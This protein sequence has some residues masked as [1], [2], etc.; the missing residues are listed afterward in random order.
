MEFGISE[1]VELRGSAVC[2]AALFFCFV[3]GEILV[4]GHRNPDTDSICSAIGYAE[5]KRL[6][7]SKRVIA[8]RCGD[9][10]DRINFVLRRFGAAPPRFVADVSPK[11]RDVMQHQVS[12]IS[13]GATASE[14]LAMMEA[15]NLRVLPIVDEDRFCHGLISVFKMGKFLMAAGNR[16]F[17]SRRVVASIRALARTLGAKLRFGVYADREEDLILMVGAMSRDSF[18]TRLPNYPPEKLIVVVGDRR[19]IQELAV[20]HR[21]RAIIVTGDLAV[22]EDVAAR[23]RRNEVSLLVS[24][25]DSATTV[26]LC[27]SAIGVEH[28]KHEHFLSFREDEAVAAIRDVAVSSQFQAFPVLDAL[29]RVVGV[30]S[31]TDLL[32]RVDRK[33]ILVDHN[34]LSQAVK[35][36]DQVEIIEIIDHHRIGAFTSRQPMLFV[37]RPVGS[38]STIVADLFFTYQLP[39]SKQIAGLLMAGLV[40]DTLNLTSPTTTELDASVLSR[41][42]VVTSIDP[43]VF[44]EQLFSSGSVLTGRPAKEAIAADCKEYTEAGKK[45]SVAQIEEIGFKNFWERKEA[46]VEALESY[47]REN[48]CFFSSLLVTDVVR[49]SSLLLAAGPEEFLSRIHYPVVEAGGAYELSGVVS[50]K[51]QLLPYLVH[52]LEH[53]MNGTVSLM[54]GRL[55]EEIVN[56]NQESLI[57]QDGEVRILLSSVEDHDVHEVL[58]RRKPIIGALEDLCARKTAAAAGLIVSETNGEQSILIGGGDKTLLSRLDLPVLE[59][60]VF[61]LNPAVRSK[62]AILSMFE[63]ARNSGGTKPIS[64]KS[65]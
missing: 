51:K 26:M 7:G 16:D 47:R 13:P 42:S 20:D 36:A 48:G 58:Q 44:T 64:V 4:I 6:T 1:V 30:L 25:H 56:M 9:V 38:T 61:S 11:V 33:L 8:A 23:A 45:F 59:K 12:C 53:M 65:P 50:R 21:V 5:F 3:V 2:E 63:K 24:P 31:K 18:A 14:A 41:L 37:N 27:R 15:G 34:E 17:R 60:N 55:P 43:A 46:V 10:N 54:A 40:S 62:A 22:E 52:C 39:L 19:D 35:G 29:K 57:S 49:Q 32:K 28:M